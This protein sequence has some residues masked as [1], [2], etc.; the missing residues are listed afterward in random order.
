M[1][2]RQVA[3]IDHDGRRRCAA[4]V[5]TFYRQTAKPAPADRRAVTLL[6][7]L[8]VLAVL[9]LLAAVAWPAL[10]RSFADG[11][12]RHAADM[13][14]AQWA[15]AQVRAITSGN[16]Q[17]FRIEADGRR[18]WTE[19]SAGSSDS[20]QDTLEADTATAESSSDAMH[21]PDGITFGALT[22]EAAAPVDTFEAG[23]LPISATSGDPAE[24]QNTTTL[25]FY[26]DGTCMSARLVLHNT[27]GRSITIS[28]QGLTATATASEITSDEDM[29]P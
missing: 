9:A 3:T 27:H 13:I 26:P 4:P 25:L 29:Q 10:D 11:E 22:I 28:M 5:A 6:E 18:C 23:S 24:G 14:R 15:E 20:A 7:L 16:V 19:A 8:L 17:Q 21:L 12:L 1:A 2:R